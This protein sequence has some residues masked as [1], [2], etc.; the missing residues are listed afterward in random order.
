MIDLTVKLTRSPSAT[1]CELGANVAILDG[2]TNQYFTLNATGAIVWDMLPAY[3]REIIARLAAEYGLP[4]SQVEDD[5]SALL[6]QL[7]SSGLICSVLGS[8][9]VSPAA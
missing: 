9:D 2:R 6:D 5:V 7:L 8:I 3:P 1:S 4:S